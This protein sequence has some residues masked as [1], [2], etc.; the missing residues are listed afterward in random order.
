MR[1]ASI[2]SFFWLLLLAAGPALLAAWLHPR[3]P[4]WNRER[5]GVAEVTAEWVRARRAAVL[6]VDARGEAAFRRDGIPGAVHLN[7]ERW[8]EPMGEFLARWQPGRLVV[9][10]CDEQ[11][12][13]SQ[14]V[15]RRLRREARIDDIYVL[16][17]GRP[18]WREPPEGER[19]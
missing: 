12:A 8:D 4:A 10:Y 11:C 1:R 3:A 13:S 5:A 6:W 19:R 16:R 9:V 18:A 14:D 15:A 17:G 7:E 2:R